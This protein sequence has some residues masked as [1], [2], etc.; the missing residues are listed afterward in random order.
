M[1]ETIFYLE[2]RGGSYLYHFFTYTL[3]GLFYISN[4]IY[5]VRGKENSSILLD[6]KS[7]ISDIP[8]NITV[9]IKIYIKDLLPFQIEAFEIIKD[10]F[11]LVQDLKTI[12]DYEIVSI[13]G[14][15]CVRSVCDNPNKIFPFLRQLFSDKLY[16]DVIPGKRIFITRKFSE[17]YHN[18][19]LKRYI[20]NE[21]KIMKNLKKYNFEFVQLEDYNLHDKIKL[22]MQ[23]EMIVSSHS[24]ALTFSMFMNKKSNLI[25]ILNQGTDGFLHKHYIEICNSLN[26]N[27]NRY[28]DIKEDLNGNFNLNCDEFEIFL[29][30]FI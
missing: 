20:I 14:E 26:L 29:N 28:T 12:P 3:G 30:K 4:G 11:E 22:F 8:N 13:Y 5:N 19:L 24:G 18:G 21:N 6:D 2:G 10:K 23:S 15:T 17:S 9:P 16:Y 7:K 25:E 1:K 27:Y